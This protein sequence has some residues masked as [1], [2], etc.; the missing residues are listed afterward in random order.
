M[1]GMGD[2][3][4]NEQALQKD[5]CVNFEERSMAMSSRLS[6]ASGSSVLS[7]P[8]YVDSR[9]SEQFGPE[10]QACG[11]CTTPSEPAKIVL[12]PVYSVDSTNLDPLQIDWDRKSKDLCTD[13]NVLKA[14]KPA[15]LA[16][17]S[18]AH[19]CVEHRQ[20]SC[21]VQSQQ[22]ACTARPKE[23]R[24]HPKRNS[25][26][27]IATQLTELQSEDPDKVICARKINR[28]GFESADIL[29]KH[30]EQYGPVDKV[31][32]SNAHRR[33]PGVYNFPVRL[34]PSGI[35]FVVFKNSKV[36]A[37]VLAVGES[38][39]VNG[40]E[41]HMRAFVR[42]ACDKSADSDDG[43]FRPDDEDA[44]PDEEDEKT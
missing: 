16:H 44:K 36:V 12:D 22:Q 3:P 31:L 2:K 28:L 24:Y 30:F 43:L 32:L 15:L 21:K 13:R 29:S 41:V 9:L 8:A 7:E 40:V 34:R 23:R 14:S 17:L 19:P 35:G 33:E 11:N 4:H 20:P 42:K 26:L 37:Q 27:Q 38:H 10:A 25:P 18:S 5:A 6:L 1:I 39:V